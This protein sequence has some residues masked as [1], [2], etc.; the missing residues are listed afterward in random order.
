MKS[1]RLNARSPSSVFRSSEFPV[2]LC[3]QV[4]KENLMNFLLF[5]VVFLSAILDLD[6]QE[7]LVC[8]PK[9]K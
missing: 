8:T 3:S 6:L 9:G 1:E 7:F 4:L 2:A 5:R